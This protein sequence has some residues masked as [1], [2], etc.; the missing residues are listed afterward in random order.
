MQ[1]LG[2]AGALIGGSS[3]LTGNPLLAPLG[4]YG[5]PT[6]TMPPLPGSPA[7]DA[8][9]S[10]ILNTDQRGYARPFGANPD[11]GAIEVTSPTNSPFGNTLI[12]N[13]VNQYVSV[14]NFGAIIPTNEITVEFWAYTTVAAGQSAFILNP[15]HSNNRFNVHINYG[16]PAPDVGVTYWDFGDITGVVTL[17][18]FL[19]RLIPSVTGFIMLS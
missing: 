3:I 4:N 10:G 16:G 9:G 11:I 17:G 19:P 5:G 2:N 1:S 12:F 13:G 14:P 6:Q 8:G 18:Q 15:D 7:I